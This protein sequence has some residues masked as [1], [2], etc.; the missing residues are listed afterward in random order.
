MI[1]Q[2]P[3]LVTSS[4]PRKPRCLAVAYPRFDTPGVTAVQVALGDGTEL[5][6]A[7]DWSSFYW[8]VV[9]QLDWRS[10]DDLWW[11]YK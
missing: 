7:N 10:I 6:V 5:F 8:Q 1:R 9:G 3:R 4:A 11:H 2:E